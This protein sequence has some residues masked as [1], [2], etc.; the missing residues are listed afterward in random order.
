MKKLLSLLFA[1]F[2]IALVASI[3]F[4]P[5]KA[6]GSGPLKRSV[7]IASIPDSIHKIFEKSCM[8]CHADD[9]NAMAKGRVNFSNWDSYKPEKQADK[10]KAILKDLEPKIKKN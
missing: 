5:S 3:I 1:T 4:L 6:K 9:G 7:P 8:D 10:A 2:V